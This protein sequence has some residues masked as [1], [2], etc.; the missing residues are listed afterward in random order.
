MT[1]QEAG[2]RTTGRRK[3][4]VATVRL[5]PG[6]GRMSVNGMPIEQYFRKEEMRV[7][8]SQPLTV[9]RTAEKYDVIAVVNGGGLMGQAGAMRHGLARA[10]SRFD[11]T[12]R[13]SLKQAGLLTRDPRAKERKKYG[14]PGARKRF[15]FSKR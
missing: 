12:T 3:T 13:Q 5:I 4:S 2:V 6:T 1:V 10:I 9:T 7:I 11:E 15:Q 8:V 14:H